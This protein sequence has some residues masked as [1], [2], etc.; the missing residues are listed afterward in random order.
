ML[1]QDAA[2]GRAREVSCLAA[3]CSVGRAETF[4]PSQTGNLSSSEQRQKEGSP[5][6]QRAMAQELGLEEGF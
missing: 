3:L 1:G 2:R 4:V 5:G 6:Q